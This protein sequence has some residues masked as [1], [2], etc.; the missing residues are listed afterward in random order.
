MS[1]EVYK[2]KQEENQTI[3]AKKDKDKIDETNEE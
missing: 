1:I 2:K 3:N